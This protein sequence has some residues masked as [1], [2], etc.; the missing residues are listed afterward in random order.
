MENERYYSPSEIAKKYN[1]K[2]GTVRKW[3]YKGDLKGIKLGG[4]WRIPES[5]LEE[6]LKRPGEGDL[7][8]RGES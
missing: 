6:F 8:R 4:L 5:A 7:T 2:E 1:L 3:L